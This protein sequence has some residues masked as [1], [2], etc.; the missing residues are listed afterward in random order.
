MLLQLR[1]RI[2]KRTVLTARVEGALSENDAPRIPFSAAP[3]LTLPTLLTALR[4]GAHDPRVAHLHLSIGALACGW[5][6]LFELRR[7]LEMFRSSGKGITVFMESG[8]AK[9]FFLAM[10]FGL[11][12]P[13]E[14]GLGL[15]GFVGSGTFVG[16]V[17]EKI[18]VE[19][20]V[21]RIGKYK[22]AGDQLMRRD[23]SSAQ[24]EVL[25]A[26]LGNVYEVWMKS[27]GEA[28]GMERKVLD[29]FLDRSPW[30]MEEYLK[31]GL[32]S[33]I[34]YESELLE[35]LK[36]RFGG[37]WE[38]EED[39]E[40][41]LKGVD[42]RKY[43]RRTTEKLVGIR[44]KK[45]IAVIRVAG[46]ITGGKNSRNPV[47]GSTVGSD[48]LVE[49]IRKVRENKKYVACLLRCDSPG[50]SALASDI[51]WNE[52]RRLAKKKPLLASQSDV[53][54]SGG[55]YLSMAS[56]II[57]EPLTITG[58]IGVVAAKPSLSEFYKKVG[59]AKENVSVGSKYAELLVDDRVFTEIEGSH[60]KA[61]V[62]QAYRRFVGKA[63]LSRGKSHEE[64]EEVAQGRVWTGLQAKERG[65]V[66]YLGG[67]ERA[68]EILKEKA[69]IPEAEHVRLETMRNQMSLAQ[70]LGLGLLTIEEKSGLS[71]LLGE[72]LALADVDI[73]E[74]GGLSP[75]SAVVMGGIM[76]PL[77]ERLGV[78]GQTQRRQS[79]EVIAKLWSHI[80]LS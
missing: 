72:P 2:P 64:M 27:V 20:Q 12:V 49:L 66:D 39:V 6:K 14:G 31:A 52:L 55:Y 21:E 68:V 78:V 59:Y 18:G 50:G 61:G 58:S 48:S 8:G 43:V 9:E 51:V 7:H 5:G 56:E 60:F 79:M 16:G 44:G 62:V 74:N 47:L 69:G 1:G 77:M 54:A 24:R 32:I 38:K 42:V 17:L 75:M 4:V 80:T 41:E 45:C 29:E 30:E 76:G 35:G 28:T 37:K 67:I 34:C 53:A 57:A 23:M 33:G 26:L 46:A 65:L 22:S 40:G 70:R 3:E 13:P 11:Y 63:A 36:K 71:T 25:E 15:R 19:P 73:S 10:G